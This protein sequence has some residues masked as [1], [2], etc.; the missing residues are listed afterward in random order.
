M[1]GVAHRA[2][3]RSRRSSA[4]QHERQ[5]LQVE[6]L[7]VGQPRQRVGVEGDERP[8][9]G[10]GDAAAGPPLEQEPHGPGREREAQ[11]SRA[12]CRRGPATPPSQRT[13]APISP[14][15][16]RCSENASVRRSGWKMLASN[17]CSGCARRLVR[18]P[19]HD[20]LVQHGVGVVVA[21]QPV[22]REASGHVCSTASATHTAN[23]PAARRR[24]RKATPDPLG[25]WAAGT[26]RYCSIR[27][28]QF[29]NA[30]RS[31]RS[32]WKTTYCARNC[33]R[34]ANDSGLGN[35]LSGTTIARNS[36]G[37]WSL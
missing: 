34:M 11:R 14:C 32:R 16:I 31:Y 22:G 23:A 15:T 21:R 25:G 18:D 6:R 5:E 2:V 19:R 27:R 29:D 28:F 20:P 4:S 7:D 8:G 24:S 17:R 9:D 33:F 36:G 37:M 35:E 3:P 12:G 30:R 10:A 26:A 13:G 1:H